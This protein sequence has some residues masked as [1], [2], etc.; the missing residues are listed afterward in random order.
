M[1]GKLTL[2]SALDIHKIIK[3]VPITVES[4]KLNDLNLKDQGLKILFTK[5]E[6]ISCRHYFNGL[7]RL[8]GAETDL[9]RY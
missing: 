7:N 9:L 8:I 2:L 4:L 3:S 5:I 1:E 6:S